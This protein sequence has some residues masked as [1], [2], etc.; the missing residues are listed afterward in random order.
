MKDFWNEASM[1]QRFLPKGHKIIVRKAFET[2]IDIH[3]LASSSSSFQRFAIKTRTKCSRERKRKQ[4]KVSFPLRK[5]DRSRVEW[6]YYYTEIDAKISKKGENGFLVLRRGREKFGGKIQ[7]TKGRA[8]L[9]P[10]KRHLFLSLSLSP[11]NIYPTRVC[12]AAPWHSFF[13]SYI[14]SNNRWPLVGPFRERE[15]TVLAVIHC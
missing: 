14:T 5:K 13:L 11:L 15:R 2:A 4:K 10:N 6:R 7:G 12:A 1:L 3:T 8:E 9:A